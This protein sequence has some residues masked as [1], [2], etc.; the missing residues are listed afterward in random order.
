MPSK[1]YTQ[2][3]E[4][5]YEAFKVLQKNNF[6]VMLGVTILEVGRMVNGEMRPIDTKMIV[7][8]QS[9]QRILLSDIKQAESIVECLTRLVSDWKEGKGLWTA[10][11]TS[12][13]PESSETKPQT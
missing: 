1:Y 8:G 9:D 12:E 11:P 5:Q 7:I 13:S 6:S 2:S 4:D 3:L 10:P